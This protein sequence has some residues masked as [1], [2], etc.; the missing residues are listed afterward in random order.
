MKQP[1]RAMERLAA[2]CLRASDDDS[3]LGDLSERYAHHHRR[4]R[5]RLGGSGWTAVLQ[6]LFADAH[7]VAAAVNVALFAQVA[8]MGQPLAALPDAKFAGLVHSE[9]TM[10]PLPSVAGSSNWLK[11]ALLLTAVAF[12]AA[13]ASDIWYTWRQTE[14]LIVGVQREKAEAAAAQIDRFVVAVRDKLAWSMDKAAGSPEQHRI[15]SLRVMRQVP[16]LAEIV[17]LDAGGKELLRV[18]RFARDTAGSGADFSGDVRYLEARKRGTYV[19]A[20][21]F[22]NATEPYVSLALA[23]DGGN[24]GVTLAE[25][26]L[27]GVNGVVRS[28]KSGESGYAFLVDG[29]GRVVAGPDTG[30]LRQHFDKSR[31]S[32]R[33]PGAVHTGLTGVPVLSAHAAVPTTGW[34][35]FVELPTTEARQPLWS[36]LLRGAGVLALGL[37]A[38]LLATAS[39]GSARPGEAPLGSSR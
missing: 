5:E 24:A 2:F 13:G 17:H 9:G 36:A 12:L 7:Y 1:P 30:T 15:D 26:S 33:D 31:W 11:P 27:L 8:G 21:Y 29:S 22:R 16:E 25:T 39:G 10:G 6:H 32:E 18:S 20:V 34:R 19:G 28:V 4:A 38:V 35:V 14:A 23:R 3:R 37:A